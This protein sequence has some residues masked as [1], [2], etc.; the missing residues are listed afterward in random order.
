MAALDEATLTRIMQAAISA[1][2][3]ANTQQISSL[4]KPELPAFDK[5]N[6]DIWIKRVESAYTRANI[7]DAKA[8]FAHLE[9][10]IGVDVDPK[11]NQFLFEGNTNEKWTEFLSYLRSLYGRS[12]KQQTLSLI[13]GTPREGRRPSQ[14]LCI[15]KDKAK[16][17]TI[18][19]ILKEQL[20]KELPAEVQRQL[21]DKVETM[22]AQEVSDAADKFFNKDGK[23]LVTAAPASI[24]NVTHEQENASFTPPFQQDA[25]PTDVNAV[26]PK[27]GQRPSFRGS[28]G[29]GSAPRGRGANNNNNNAPRY[30]SSGKYSG[31]NSDNG[32]NSNSKGNKLCKYHDRFGKEARQCEPF[33]LMYPQHQAAKGKASQ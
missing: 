27:Q 17:V 6:I 10:K 18:D 32:N 28:N 23:L 20:L 8:K 21:T 13:T 16:D 31:G 19:D 5:A 4:R 7:T 3:A 33:C 9:S 2:Q 30:N 11:I 14:L 1:S 25:D 15:M 26:R 12:R 29:R 22:T 24:N